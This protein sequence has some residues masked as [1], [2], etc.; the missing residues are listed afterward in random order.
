MKEI[1][2]TKGMVAIVDDEDYEWLIKRKWHFHSSG[3]YAARR[4]W[5]ENKISLMHR[6]IMNTPDGMDTDHKNR[7][8]L[9][10]RRHN[11]RICTRSQNNLNKGREIRNKSGYKG[12]VWMPGKKLWR[13]NVAGE[14]AGKFKNIIDAAKAYDKKAIEMFGEFARTNF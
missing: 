1:K 10:N 2:L 11:L 12:V 6:E 13:V 9:D 8:G 14:Y 7:N 3:G 5:P 4:K